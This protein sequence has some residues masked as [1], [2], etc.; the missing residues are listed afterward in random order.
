[1]F[2]DSLLDEIRSRVKPSEVV[3]RDHKLKRVKAG[4]FTVAGDESFTIN[5][6]KGLI[7]DFGRTGFSGDI[8]R[9]QMQFHGLTFV[10][11]VKAFASQA[12]VPIPGDDAP[13]R[14]S[15]SPARSNGAEPPPAEPGDPGPDD[16]SWGHGAQLARGS[17]FK[18]ICAYDYTDRDGGLRYQ[19]VRQERIDDKGNRKKI[20]PQRRPAPGEPGVW[21][22]SLD[23]GQF[24][25]S[26]NGESKDWW[27]AT[28]ERR[29]KWGQ[30]AEFK[31]FPDGEANLLY[32]F[33][34]LCEALAE[35]LAD[36]PTV[37]FP[38]G[39]KDVAT[40]V[41]WDFTATTMSGGTRNLT[42]ENADFFLGADVIIP[43]DN[44]KAGRSA[45][46]KKALKLRGK[47]RSVKVLDWR[48]HWDS[49]PD[50]CDITDWR[51]YAGGTK[52]ALYKIARKLVEWTPEP[53][54][55]SFKA[56]RFLDLDRPAQ[57][58]QWLIK[59]VLTRGE[60]SIWW[61][62]PG[63]GKSF[64][65][66]DAAMAIARG[67]S[68]FGQPVEQGLV[69]YQA[70]EGAL[71]LKKRI[72]AYRQVNGIPK[73]E[74]LP[75]VLLPERLNL[76][77]DGNDT[78]RLIAEI[79]A[80]RDFYS[81]SLEMVI[82]D[83][84]SAAS[85]GANE[86]ASEDVGRVLQ[87]CHNIAA[88]LG[89]HVALVHHTTKA[90]GSPRGWS[91]LVGNVENSIEVMRLETEKIMDLR[92]DGS[93]IPRDKRQFWIRKQKD[94]EDGLHWDFTLPQVFMG[95]DRDNEPITSCVIS[96]PD[97]ST[98]PS[99]GEK[100]STI[101]PGYVVLPDGARRGLNALIKAIEKAGIGAP[102]NVKGIPFDVHR[103]VTVSAW[104][105]QVAKDK[106]HNDDPTGTKRKGAANKSIERAFKADW[107]V[108]F[109]KGKGLIG[110]SEC[111]EYVWRN[112]H[113]KVHE[114]DPPPE[115]PP[116]APTKRN[117]AEP[118]DAPIPT[119]HGDDRD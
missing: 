36:R 42:D 69:I 20:F 7:H 81:A 62:P 48:D 117:A 6:T 18:T 60:V 74:D 67:V 76:F 119:W 97:G 113:R 115:P 83:T 24:M 26:K 100:K 92:P 102:P 35:P 43:M 80:W 72:R 82:V 22:W 25:R 64:L 61:G 106:V 77:I 23:P 30:Y 114:I 101:P 39:E 75:F 103:V 55:S 17:K 111:G 84:F 19:V 16:S 52:E 53:P 63:C 10:E 57:E 40:L 2:S 28:D 3:G 91:G 65:I 89:T 73:S 11:A 54:E 118:D 104:R 44:D 87:R 99:T 107:D 4:E 21:I 110:R 108:P 93:R 32:R 86:N 14:S 85:I 66:L 116:A 94:G 47:A 51:D 58:L 8:F 71:G 95:H 88:K 50:K 98:S 90:G 79:E 9:Y 13:R 38:E 59:R 33:P 15:R 105:D 56:I 96:R 112:V 37:W 34:E 70:G 29:G 46:H 27:P 78:E 5:D 49:C 109:P 1:M 41:D 68:W 31:T 45:A 12:G